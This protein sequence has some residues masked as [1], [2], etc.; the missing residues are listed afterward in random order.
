MPVEDKTKDDRRKIGFQLQ[1]AL[2][3]NQGAKKHKLSKKN[4]N[5]MLHK[6]QLYLVKTCKSKYF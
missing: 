4:C 1:K 3:Y 6:D 5:S 2:L